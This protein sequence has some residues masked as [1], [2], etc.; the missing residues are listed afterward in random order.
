MMF[1]VWWRVEDPH[2]FNAD[3]DPSLNYMSDPDPSRLHFEPP[4]L[5]C[6]RP[7][8]S[9]APFWASKPLRDP[10]PPFHSNTDPDPASQVMRIHANPG[11]QSCCVL[12]SSHRNLDECCWPV[13]K[14][15]DPDLEPD[16]EL[17]GKNDPPK[18]ETRENFMFW[19]ECSL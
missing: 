9:T 15:P 12:I 10:D 18:R 5:H 14:R 16:Q 2:Q 7:P 3:L 19:R 6:E 4:H 11:P 13:V 17:G 1:C 8:P